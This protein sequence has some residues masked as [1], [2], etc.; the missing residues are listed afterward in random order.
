[1]GGAHS[2]AASVK[3][4]DIREIGAQRGLNSFNF[5]E[6]ALWLNKLNNNSRYNGWVRRSLGCGARLGNTLISIARLT[7]V[8]AIKIALFLNIL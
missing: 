6:N 4:L 8:V 7:L 1:M 2:D 3:R 5:I